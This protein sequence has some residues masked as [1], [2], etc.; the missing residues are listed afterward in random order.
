MQ[1]GDHNVGWSLASAGLIA[2][3]LVSGLWW[4]Y[5]HAESGHTERALHEA[6]GV[7]QSRLARDVYSYLHIP[8]VLGVALMAVG[9]KQTLAARDDPLDTIVAVALGSGVAMYYAALAAIRVRRGARPQ[10]TQL[11]L[12]VIVGLVVPAATK[13]PSILSLTTLA[14]AILIANCVKHLPP[15]RRPYRRPRL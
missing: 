2:I 13:L 9:I 12:V 11:A 8:L 3:V 1:G 15:V 4:S 7:E 5:F 14:V 10:M 6:D